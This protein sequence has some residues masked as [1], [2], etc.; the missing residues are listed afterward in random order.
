MRRG[1]EGEWE[2]FASELALILKS[3]V[4]WGGGGSSRALQRL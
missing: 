3:S 4:E 1:I 2:L